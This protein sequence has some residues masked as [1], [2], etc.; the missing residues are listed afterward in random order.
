MFLPHPLKKV[1]T[2]VN[3]DIKVPSSIEMDRKSLS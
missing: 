2:S 3:R 1:R